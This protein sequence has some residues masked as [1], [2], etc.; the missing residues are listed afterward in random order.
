[1]AYD[2]FVSHSSKDKPIADAVCANLEAAGVRC[3]IAPRDI[4]AG[5]DWPRAIANAISQSHIMVLIFST[6]ANSSDQISRE[7]SVAADYNLVIIPFKIDNVKPEPGKQYYLSRTHWLDAMNPPTQNQI[8]LLVERVKSIIPVAGT[9]NLEK[10]PLPTPEPKAASLESKPEVRDLKQHRGAVKRP[11]VSRRAVITVGLIVLG[12]GLLAV[13]FKP[14]SALPAQLFAAPTLTFIPTTMPTVT[15]TLRPSP[16]PTPTATPDIRIL[17]PANRHLYLY[18]K[19]SISWLNATSYCASWGGHLVT[20]QDDA[21]NTFIYKLTGG[22][23]WMGANRDGYGGAWHWVTG[24]PWKFIKWGGYPPDSNDLIYL[25][26]TADVKRVPMT[27]EGRS[28][29]NLAFVC[30][31]EPASP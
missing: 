13:F 10:T 8:N 29:D 16:K 25:L 4:A 15:P 21:E 2:A 27:W 26:L 30:E 31:W 7:L 19:R 14:L 12:L 20:I 6:N 1:L 23:I 18:V 24:E 9:S 22:N 28:S 17:N 5:E 3:W 11:G